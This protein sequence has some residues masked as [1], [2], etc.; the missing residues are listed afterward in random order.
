MI[1]LVMWVYL[2]DT[3][4]V[5]KLTLFLRLSVDSPR[6]HKPNIMEMMHSG[7][8]ARDPFS[9]GVEMCVLDS[10]SRIV[11]SG[12]IEGISG[13]YTNWNFEGASPA[14]FPRHN[15]MHRLTKTANQTSRAKPILCIRPSVRSC[16]RLKPAYCENQRKGPRVTFSCSLGLP[17]SDH[18]LLVRPFPYK[19]RGS[20]SQVQ[21]VAQVY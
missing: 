8:S 1:L 2:A 6:K 16:G 9:N 17:P 11:S 20:G 4:P 7:I 18:L 5:S 14:H 10:T 21:Q 13:M 12:S 15:A 19:S 3:L